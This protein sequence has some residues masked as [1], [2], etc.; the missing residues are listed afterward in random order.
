[1]TTNSRRSADVVVSCLGPTGLTLARRGDKAVALERERQFQGNAPAVHIE[2]ERL[3][4]FQGLA[5]PR[6]LRAW[7]AFRIGRA[8]L[9][10]RLHPQK[11]T[12][13]SRIQ[14]GQSHD[15]VLARV[16]RPDPARSRFLV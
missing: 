1:M 2:D 8:G 7:R 12:C 6:C 11:L 4:I 9:G 3:L 10:A 14:T 5:M 15:F 13:A 16:A